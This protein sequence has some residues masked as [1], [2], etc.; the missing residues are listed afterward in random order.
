GRKEGLGG[1]FR[2]ATLGPA[3]FDEDGRINPEIGYED[4]ARFV[5]YLATGQP[6]PAEPAAAPFLGAASGV[7]V[8]LLYNGVLKDETEHGGNVL[9]RALL[10]NLPPHDGPRIVYGAASRVA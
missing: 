3:V 9:T 10:D 8:Y 7:G 6:M 2:F 5:F 1:G 4:L